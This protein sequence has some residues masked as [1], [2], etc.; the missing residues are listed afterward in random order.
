MPLVGGEMYVLSTSNGFIA[1]YVDIPG[2]QSQ[3]N[4]TVSTYFP[5]DSGSMINTSMPALFH[6]RQSN[7]SDTNDA[8]YLDQF[9][10]QLIKYRVDFIPTPPQYTVSILVRLRRLDV[11]SGWGQSLR[12]DV[13]LKLAG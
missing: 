5:V 10:T 3:N 4:L 12:L 7:F 8:G 11:D 6:V 13:L 9:S 1:G 2:P